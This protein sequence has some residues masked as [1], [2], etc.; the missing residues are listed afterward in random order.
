MHDGVYQNRYEDIRFYARKLRQHGLV[1][2]MAVFDLS[3]LANFYRLVDDGELAPP[4]VFEFVF[5]VPSGLPYKDR[6]LEL[7]VKELP[8]EAAWFCFRHHQQ[9]VFGL[10]RVL[11]LGGHIRVGYEDSPFLS[12]GRHAPDNI[13]LVEDA[14]REA[15][16]AGRSP[17]R[18][19]RAREIM[20]LIPIAD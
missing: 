13:A 17:V 8:P 12:D 16:K 20:G 5:D 14:A 11:E 15:E 6:Y 4:Y 7:F 10:R 1:P 19:A 9:G 18:A 2:T 3:H